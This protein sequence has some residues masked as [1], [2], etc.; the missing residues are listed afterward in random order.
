MNK[1]DDIYKPISFW[2]W[3][4]DMQEQ[5][6]RWQIREMKEQ[7]FGGFFIHSRAGRL[8]PYM[9]PQWIQACGYAID[10]AR[11]QGLDVWL[12]DEDGWPSGFAGGAV[13]GMDCS[14]WARSLVFTESETEC[15]NYNLVCMYKK[16]VQGYERTD[17]TD[18][19]SLFCYEETVP[20]YVDLMNPAVTTA[21]IQVTHEV[22]KKHFGEFF[23]TTIKGIFTDEP[24]LLG[25]FPWSKTLSKKY[26]ETYNKDIL[27][28]LWQLTEKDGA[29][30]FKYRYRRLINLL[31]Q[32]NFIRQINDW[33]ENNHI[34][35][36]GHV[37][38]EDGLVEQ[39]T[40]NGGVMPLYK[41]MGMPGIDHLG[42]RYTSAN[43]MKQVTSVAHR[44]GKKQV[45]SES[46][47][48]SGWNVSFREL[49]GIAGWQAVFG[50]N[51]IC[52]HLS[53][54]SLIGRRKRDYPPVFSY[55]EPWWK[56]ANVLMNA[57][58][59][60]NGAV[61][62]GERLT[63][64][65]VI[66]PM[67]SAWCI[68]TEKSKY[69]SSAFRELQNHLLDLHIDYDLLDES[70]LSDAK[71]SENGLTA[72]RIT[73]NTVIVPEAFTLSAVT[74]RRIEEFANKGGQ[75]YF[76]QNR[77][78][79]IE[80]EE[81]HELRP[82]LMRIPALEVQNSRT[83]LQKVF[84]KYPIDRPYDLLDL[85]YNNEVEGLVSRYVVN[86]EGA[87][88]YCFNPKRGA[89]ITTNLR[90]KGQIHIE[91][92]NVVTGEN[93]PVQSAFDGIYT[94]AKVTIPCGE[95]KIFIMK[96]QISEA[97]RKNVAAKTSVLPL[98]NV[99]TLSPNCFTLDMGRISIMDQAYSDE[100]YVLNSVDEIYRQIQQS[101]E[102]GVIKIEY[103]FHADFQNAIPELLLAYEANSYVQVAVN[104]KSITATDGWFVDKGIATTPIGK[105]VQNGLNRILLSYHIPNS[106]KV[107]DLDTKFESER[108]R[109]FYDVEPENIYLLGDFDLVC[110]GTVS[111]K[112][113][114]ISVSKADNRELFVLTDSSK[115]KCGDMTGQNLWFY[116]GN[117]S[118]DTE[119]FYEGVGR[120]MISLP[121]MKGIFAEAYL[122]NR[123]IATILSVCDQC[124][125]TPYLKEGWNRVT[126][127]LHGSNR[128]LLGPHHHIMEEQNF[129]GPSTYSGVKGWEDFVSPELEEQ[130]TYTDNYAFVP[131]GI[132]TCMLTIEEFSKGEEKV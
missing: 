9:G 28:E 29:Y 61:S 101:M 32:E 16:N 41:Y 59:R 74:V 36:T 96:Q 95:G 109:F 130:N 33:C 102:D 6:L 27:D 3:N 8:I 111:A 94:H 64:V 89:E 93:E 68:G 40:H 108:N 67:A 7:G 66:H 13:N 122:D 115:K 120:Y 99:K 62:D 30:A 79:T 22:Y 84:R 129:V 92:R 18:E 50:V 82:T 48:C 15:A 52:T 72:G 121:D 73:Y 119:V 1:K 21:F 56:E 85:D 58:A 47:G 113:H 71:V 76:M 10:E 38:H 75:V 14:Y 128:N 26:Q 106:G 86:E 19:A 78:Q 116:R 123:K 37:S 97:C 45:L 20:T 100:T 118:Y 11:K 5:E 17:V 88:L 46:Y 104:G 39:L 126:I 112:P 70:E 31:F 98:T 132:G 80:G 124:D 69:I 42:N 131:F 23:G 55:Q 4:G 57:I 2:S 54:Y 35:F 81:D 127:I 90:C 25:E 91:E 77:P 51:T 87:V 110:E 103:C 12:Y 24:Q 34:L 44:E 107:N 117:V 43:L 53:A 105:L 83:I 63:H 49:L 65:A 114:A 125:I 60:L